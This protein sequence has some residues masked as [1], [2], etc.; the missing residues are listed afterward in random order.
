MVTRITLYCGL[1][2]LAIGTGGCFMAA[3]AVAPMAMQLVRAAGSGVASGTRSAQKANVTQEAET[4]S[5]GDRPLPPLIEL[6]TDKLGTTLYRPMTPGRPQSDPQVTAIVNQTGNGRW[7]VAGNFTTMN[8][9][10]PLQRVLVPSS[11]TYLAYAPAEARDLSEQAQ[12]GALSQDFGSNTGT[13][14]WNGRS[15]RYTAVHQLPCASPLRHGVQAAV[16][17]NVTEGS[18]ESKTSL[19]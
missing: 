14:D 11:T 7:R 12:I 3:M 1:T 10:P 19:H 17:A 18:T 5:M 2:A 4:C 15:F 9:Q 8:F 16:S 13:F 6:R